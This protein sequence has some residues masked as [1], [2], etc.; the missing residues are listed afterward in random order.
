MALI[1]G[2]MSNRSLVPRQRVEGIEQGPPG[3][4]HREHELAAPLMDTGRGGIHRVQR[5]RRHDLVVQVDL[6][7]HHRGHRVE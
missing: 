5:I 4:F 2:G 7:Q 1:G 3:L 6:V